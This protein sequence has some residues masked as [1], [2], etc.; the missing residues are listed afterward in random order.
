MNGYHVLALL[1][2]ALI[3]MWARREARLYEQHKTDARERLAAAARRHEV[4]QPLASVTQMWPRAT[5]DRR[6][7]A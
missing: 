5:D 1:F 4:D 7:A 3:W 6:P 2:A